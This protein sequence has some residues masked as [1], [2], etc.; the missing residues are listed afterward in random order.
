MF[1]GSL[2][3]MSYWSEQAETSLTFWNMSTTCQYTQIY[4]HHVVSSLNSW[5]SLQRDLAAQKSQQCVDRAH[6]AWLN[7]GLPMGQSTQIMGGSFR[8][9]PNSAVVTFQLDSLFS[10]RPCTKVMGEKQDGSQIFLYPDFW[11]AHMDLILNSGPALCYSSIVW[12]HLNSVRNWSI[13][14]FFAINSI[15][16]NIW[17]WSSDKYKVNTCE[18]KYRGQQRSLLPAVWSSQNWM[19]IQHRIHNMKIINS[20]Q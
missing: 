20:L 2:A 7:R 12:F 9:G 1:T 5:R 11:L 13:D 18:T 19:L 14:K 15:D 17:L 16:K 10:P 8:Q 6:R 3:E 4:Q